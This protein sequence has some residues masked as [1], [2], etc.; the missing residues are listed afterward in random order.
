MPQRD[1]PRRPGTAGA[2]S[3]PPNRKTRHD[4]WAAT[5]MRLTGGLACVTAAVLMTGSVAH[6]LPAN[7]NGNY[8]QILCANPASEEGVGVAGMPEGLSNP[9]SIDTWQVTT[10]EFDCGDGRMT[11]ARGVPMAVGMGATYPQGT[12]SALLYEAPANVTINAGVIYRA[13]KAEGPDAGFMGII[14]QGGEYDSLYSLPRNGVDQGDWFVG[15]IAARGTFSWPF[16]PENSV[17]LTISPDGS[18][19]DVNATCDPNGNNNSSCTLSAGQWEYR[20]FGGEVS[21]HAPNDPQASNISGSLTS[22]TPLRGTDSVTFSATDEGP[23]LAYVKVLVDGETVQSQIIDTN[24]GRCIPVPGAGPYTWAYQMPCKTS[25][26]GHTYEL[27]TAS[28]KDGTHHIQVVIEDAAGN[29]SIVLDRTLA[30][31]NAPANSDPP[32]ISAASQVFGGT[33][34][35]ASPGAWSTP[36][37]AGPTAYTYQWEDCDPQGED[38]TAIAG[39]QA[40][41]YAPSAVDIGHSLRVLVD[42]T[43]TDGSTSLSS[44]P[45]SAVA[46]APGSLAEPPPGGGATGA[47]A[48]GAARIDAANGAN[49]SEGAR[50]RLD[51]A[52]A[53]SRSFAQRALRLT[54]RLVNDHGEPIGGAR[55]NVIEQIASGAQQMLQPA[56][57]SPSGTF[58]VSVAPGPSRTVTV[59]Y[60]AYVD[61]AGYSA[62]SLVK[63]NVA[64]GV[65]LDVSPRAIAAT[66][67]ITLSGVV[68]GPIPAQGAIVELLVHYRGHWEPFRAPRTNA[69]GHFRATYQF[70]GA[71]GRFPFRAE[72]PA[73]QAGYPYTSGYSPPVTV[74][75]T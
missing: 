55:L 43:D 44:A 67:M 13:E 57:T 23:G 32:T 51:G 11:P 41:S 25:V 34:L 4:G 26:G 28:L 75:A 21:L 50:L 39:A 61:D 6:A 20:I 72:V 9:A 49:A 7:G 42:A 30:T 64:A 71:I 53:I 37:G 70:E 8:T 74:S 46:A 62:E 2:P 29:Q 63:E 18:H 31:N 24:D 73:G 36:S 40:S 52:A 68:E 56:Q 27:N 58:T 35:S 38:C 16:S 19:W 33:E 54:G 69:A 45:T 66:G 10:S 59:A 12:W 3:P 65:R 48:P 60:R 22:E 47:P 14:Q 1:F 17:N 5:A 15:N